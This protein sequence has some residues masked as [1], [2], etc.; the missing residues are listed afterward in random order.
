MDVVIKR[1]NRKAA[2]FLCS[3]YIISLSHVKL[4][5]AIELEAGRKEKKRKNCKRLQAAA[6]IVGVR[7]EESEDQ[8]QMR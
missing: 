5:V 6:S 2:R 8:Y 3:A 4:D 1:R 7:K